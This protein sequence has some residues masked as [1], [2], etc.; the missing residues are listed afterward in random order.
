MRGLLFAFRLAFR[1]ASLSAL[2]LAP[3]A[4]TAET[5]PGEGCAEPG[6]AC[7]DGSQCPQYECRCVDGRFERTR[8]C[9]NGTCA[10]GTEACEVFCAPDGTSAAAE[11]TSVSCS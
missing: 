3:A 8:F 7:D 5:G 6:E 4:C 2:L 1:L 11:A 9:S 10:D